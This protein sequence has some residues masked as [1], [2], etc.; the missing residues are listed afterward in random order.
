LHFASLASP[1]YYLNYPIESLLVNSQGT[2]SL[3]EIARK[4]NARFILAS[5]SEVYGDPLQHPQKESYWG[6]VNPVGVRSVYD[7]GEAFAESLSMAYFR[8]FEIDVRIIRIFN[9]YGPR[10]GVND[11]RVMPNFIVNAL[12]NEDIENIWERR[13]NKKFLLYR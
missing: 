10:M 3:L 2:L 6:N 1:K 7:E 9:T 11:G 5:T 13:T 4:Q 12:K 8:K